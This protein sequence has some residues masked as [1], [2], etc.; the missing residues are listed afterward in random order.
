MHRRAP[1]Y[2][3]GRRSS[4]EVDDS[5]YNGL[6]NKQVVYSYQGDMLKVLHAGLV[7]LNTIETLETSEVANPAMAYSALT[8]ATGVMGLHSLADYYRRLTNSILPQAGEHQKV[9]SRALLGIYAAGRADW[10]EARET[11]GNVVNRF[12]EIGAFHSA[13]ESVGY[14]GR[15]YAHCGDYDRALDLLSTSYARTKQRNDRIIRFHLFT[16]LILLIIRRDSERLTAFNDVFLLTDAAEAEAAFSAPFNANPLNRGAYHALRALGFYA[17]G[18]GASAFASL[19]ECARLTLESRVERGM[20]YFELYALLPESSYAL[21]NDDALSPADRARSGDIFT[22]SLKK[23]EKYARTFT[24]A[25]PRALLYQGWQHAAN[26]TQACDLWRR[27][28]QFAQ[29]LHMPYD[30]ALAHT[31]LSRSSAVPEAQRRTH[32]A[33]ARRLFESLGAR[34]DLARLDNSS[35]GS[36]L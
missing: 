31:A 9:L 18:D 2:Y 5:I 34:Y 33:E 36:S 25:Q 28:L 8:L 22:Q 32:A 16:M 19:Q 1:A 11:I 20:L 6:F 23:L 21:M 14:L 13:D 29:S 12:N 27:S 4:A 35:K 15:V 10:D 24:L 17:V 3:L 30:Q 7:A 26:P